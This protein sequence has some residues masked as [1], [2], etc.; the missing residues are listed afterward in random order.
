MTT[1][2][3]LISWLKLTILLC[4]LVATHAAVWE[5]GAWPIAKFL[6]PKFTPLTEVE[7]EKFRF[8]S[9][10]FKNEQ[11]VTALNECKGWQKESG[12]YF[13]YRYDECMRLGTYKYLLHPKDIH[14]SEVISPVAEKIR[15]V[16]LIWLF[17]LLYAVF[18]ILM[19]IPLWR[20]VTKTVIPKLKN[21][22]EGL[23]MRV[24]DESIL[25]SNRK[26]S[27][28]VKQLDDLE[29]LHDRG[30]ISDDVFRERKAEI[31]KALSK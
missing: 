26:L 31:K 21:Y 24:N 3:F 28:A 16:Y 19:L 7:E 10:K 11:M 9:L 30:M 27:T 4:A 25:W 5:F 22:A 23:K 12:P 15:E 2:Q 14:E 18:A 20:W 8:S 17:G 6:A 1:K 13:K 29:S